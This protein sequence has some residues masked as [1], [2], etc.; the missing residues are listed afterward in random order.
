MTGATPSHISHKFISIADQ[1]RV[2]NRLLPSL[3]TMSGVN[4]TAASRRLCPSTTHHAENKTYNAERTTRTIL[5]ELWHD[6]EKNRHVPR[7]PSK[8]VT[9]LVHRQHT[10]SMIQKWWIQN[11]QTYWEKCY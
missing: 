11:L 5:R 6:S 7:A 8:T 10:P 2:Q 9:F 1:I 3:S 4:R